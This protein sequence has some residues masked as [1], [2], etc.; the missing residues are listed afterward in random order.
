MDAVNNKD[1]LIRMVSD[2]GFKLS[3]LQKGSLG[4]FIINDSAVTIKKYFLSQEIEPEVILAFS[5]FLSSVN[6]EI[7]K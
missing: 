1:A 7:K 5:N 3:R 6:T 2:I 4:E